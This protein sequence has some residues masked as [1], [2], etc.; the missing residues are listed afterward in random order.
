MTLTQRAQRALK[1]RIER[2]YIPFALGRGLDRDEAR[3]LCV[4]RGRLEF[5]AL[6]GGAR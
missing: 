1:I 3:R 4:L 2:L 5:R 6:F